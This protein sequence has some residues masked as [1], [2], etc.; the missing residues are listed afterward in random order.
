VVT[1][2]ERARTFHWEMFRSDLPTPRDWG[3]GVFVT[4]L[5]LFGVGAAAATEPLAGLV[6]GG[7]F[8]VFWGGLLLPPW[9]RDRRSV[10][11]ADIRSG[12]PPVLVLRRRSG[13]EVTHRLDAVTELRPLTLGYRSVD[14]G[15]SDVLEL[16]VGRK[17]YRT[18]A[19]FNPPENDVRLL[20]EA[21]RNALPQVK[22]HRHENRTSW[23][24]ESE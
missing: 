20:Q 11:A 13:A 17:A 21:L 7:T 6:L 24:S 23:V 1:E 16:R 12:P 14:G 19:A 22:V 18:R 4:L 8:A 10:V 9:I 2:D 5:H 15:G 3:S